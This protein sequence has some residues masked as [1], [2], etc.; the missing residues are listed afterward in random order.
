MR[1]DYRSENWPVDEN[2]PDEEYV[3]YDKRRPETV[4]FSD[5][6]M[7]DAFEIVYVIRTQEQMKAR[8][9]YNSNLWDTE[10]WGFMKEHREL[11]LYSTPVRDVKISEKIYDKNARY[12]AYRVE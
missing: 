6:T 9:E 3:E 4:R 11:N 10:K 12:V 2:Y 8:P 5:G 7:R 1:R